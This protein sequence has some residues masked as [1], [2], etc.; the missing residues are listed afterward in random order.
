MLTETNRGRAI[1]WFNEVWNKGQVDV[2][3][4][5]AHEDAVSHDLEGP[6]V[7]TAGLEGFRAF[8]GQL[9]GAIP[10]LHISI[11]DTIAEGERVVLRT[12]ARGTHLGEQLGIPPTGNSIDFAS[13]VILQF[14]DGKIAEAWNFLDQ[15]SFY[16]QLH[17]LNVR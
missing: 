13:V 3:A 6:G 7:T 1:R 8:H 15:L 2:I 14:R 17:I 12:H 16:Q 5:L 9:C 10:D 11:L 4:E